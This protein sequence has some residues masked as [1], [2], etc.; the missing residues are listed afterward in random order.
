MRES[1]VISIPI[2]VLRK[3]PLSS[4]PFNPL[5]TQLLAIFE[6]PPSKVAGAASL[7][8]SAGH[9]SSHVLLR[10]RRGDTDMAAAFLCHCVAVSSA[11][12]SHSLRRAR[13]V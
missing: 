4:G 11:L 2:M 5:P 9:N 8:E 10:V 6:P 1:R 13:E 12:P 7:A 3:E